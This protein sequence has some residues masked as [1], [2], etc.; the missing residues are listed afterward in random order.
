M[1]KIKKQ[2]LVAPT[3]FIIADLLFCLL[4]FWAAMLSYDK[5]ALEKGGHLLSYP[6]QNSSFF[7]IIA[8][9]ERY[10]HGPSILVLSTIGIISPLLAFL[11]LVPILLF[12]SKPSQWLGTVLFILWL[13]EIFALGFLTPQVYPLLVHA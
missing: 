6:A 9:I 4:Y 10:F 3:K 7:T 2:T 11:P 12:K 5:W 1:F 8:L 13:G